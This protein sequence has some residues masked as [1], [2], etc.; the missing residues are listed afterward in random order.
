M[1]FFPQCGLIAG[2][3]VRELVDLNHHHRR[4]AEG[5][6]HRNANGAEHRDRP[7][8]TQA[9]KRSHQGRQRKTQKNGKR[10]RDE[11]FPREIQGSD[12]DCAD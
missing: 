4:E 2:K 9:L 10:D 12:D 8:Q 3:I 5:D 6:C 1:D 11:D 7:R